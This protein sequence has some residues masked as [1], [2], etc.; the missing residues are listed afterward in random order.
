MADDRAS[1]RRDI[2]PWPGYVVLVEEMVE[3]VDRVVQREVGVVNVARRILNVEA[4]ARRAAA[5]RRALLVAWAA[6][7]S[8]TVSAATLWVGEVRGTCGRGVRNG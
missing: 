3:P 2:R 1:E 5:R 4:R 7:R 6:W 8:R